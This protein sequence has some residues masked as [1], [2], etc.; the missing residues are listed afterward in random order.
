MQQQFGGHSQ[1]R[2][3]P[4]LDPD[5]GRGDMAE[6]EGDERVRPLLREAR[7]RAGSFPHDR[8]S[9]GFS[10]RLL[11]RHLAFVDLSLRDVHTHRF[12]L[13]FYGFCVCGD[14]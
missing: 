12:G 8:F 13:L 11:P 3:F 14:Q 9:G 10:R 5:L 4:P 1:L 2:D 7:Y 6:H